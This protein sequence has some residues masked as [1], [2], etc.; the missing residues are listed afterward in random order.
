MIVKYLLRGHSSDESVLNDLAALLEQSPEE[1]ADILSHTQ[2][3]GDIIDA[4]L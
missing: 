2:C 3:T 1:H 4:C